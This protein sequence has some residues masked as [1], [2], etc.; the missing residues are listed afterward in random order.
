MKLTFEVDGVEVLSR[1]LQNVANTA[2][3]LTGAFE[4]A[5]KEFYIAETDNFQSSNTS[6]K[7]GKWKER[8]E[9]YE[10]SLG[11]FALL[12]GIERRSDRLYKSLTG[13]RENSVTKIGKKEAVF[14]TS[15]PYAKAQHYG[16][17]PRNLP[18]RPLIDLSD[19]Q[20]KKIFDVMKKEIYGAIK[21]EGFVMTESNT[22]DF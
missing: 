15:L 21:K 6:G 9:K 1:K 17:E 3:D 10:N 20:L 7:S 11:T 5:Q 16:Y 2:E 12:A 8:S 13:D 4:A 18:S 22:G 14:G 19:K